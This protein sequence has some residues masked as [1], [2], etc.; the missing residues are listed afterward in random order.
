M[1]PL[2]P[3]KLKTVSPGV[4]AVTFTKLLDKAGD[5]GAHQDLRKLIRSMIQKSS[6]SD[7][8][9]NSVVSFSLDVDNG[10]LASAVR[11]FDWLQEPIVMN[12]APA[13]KQVT[14]LNFL[15]PV[16]STA[17]FRELKVEAPE[18][19]KLQLEM[20]K[21]EAFATPSLVLC[22]GS[23]L[24]LVTD[25]A[26]M[27]VNFWA[28]CLECCPDFDESVLWHLLKTIAVLL[29]S[30]DGCKWAAA[31]ADCKGVPLHIVHLLQVAVGRL[32]AQCHEDT[33]MQAVPSKVPVSP[34]MFQDASAV[35]GELEKTLRTAIA[36][37]AP[38]QQLRTWPQGIRLSLGKDVSVGS[39]KHGVDRPM[40]EPKHKK[41]KG[42][43]DP[44][45]DASQRLAN[46][47]LGVLD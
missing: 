11:L 21:K 42:I 30:A 9:L 6:V 12:L 38:G 25:V 24:E 4:L 10:A 13:K 1:D 8:R 5:S 31:V 7:K 33:H 16:V 47:K 32:I 45:A 37:G 34:M 3:G 14:L 35:I 29:D 41:P 18:S 26:I 22:L 27:I 44:V 20:G 40:D 15:P 36:L 39:S 43:Q 19:K 28:F 17:Q 46:T 2:V 23:R